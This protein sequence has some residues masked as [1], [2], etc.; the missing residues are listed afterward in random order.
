MGYDIML[1]ADS[2]SRWAEAMRE[3]GGRL[4]EM[5]GEEGF[6]SYM[7][8]RLSTF[9]ERAGSINCL[10][11]PDR[12][13]SLTVAGAVSPPGADFSEPVTQSTIRIIDA[14][15]ALD[16]SLANKRHFPAISWLTSYSLYVDAVKEWWT[17]FDPGWEE[18]RAEAIKILQQEAE[19]EEIVRLVG[20]ESLPQDDK[21]LLL[22]ARMIREDF[23]QQSAYH[24]VDTYCMPGKA[25][26][27]LKTIIK[28]N[29][30]S[31]KM[32]SSGIEIEQI[33]SLPIVYKIARL[34]EVPH[35][36]FEQRIKEL[37]A[38]RDKSMVARKGG[39]S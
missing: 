35:D 31:Q 26:L 23:L 38:E 33:R 7:G 16:V 3:M 10:G 24:E 1:V 5:P 9:Y 32:L 30:L 4:E 18:T 27:M 11:K 13:G 8:S 22:I 25:G 37:W 2:T 34:K 15:Y 28:F 20:P 12:K 36:I 29:V 14:L 21:L 17:K 6:P 19:L 39:I